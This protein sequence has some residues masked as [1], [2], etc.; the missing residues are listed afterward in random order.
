MICRSVDVKSRV[1]E[2]AVGS[3]Q[4]DRYFYDPLR[5]F[6]PEKDEALM[7][8]QGIGFQEMDPFLR[9]LLVTDGT[10]TRCLEAYL[11]EPISVERCFQEEVLLKHNEP[12]LGVKEGEPVILRKII[13]RGV[14]T[15]KVYTF[16]ESLIRIHLLEEEIQKD[17]LEGRM[18]IGELLR[19]RRLETYREMLEFGREKAGEQLS[20]YFMIKSVDLICYRRYRIHVK[21]LP[22]I[23][24]TENFFE[25]HFR[26]R[27]KR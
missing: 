13:L 20:S 22:V 3:Q 5:G 21:G 12:L 27:E 11:W 17:L 1:K 2:A 18:G 10:V 24:V 14:R 8:D 26:L 25:D 19:D 6:L 9:V 15:R 7:P 16:A 4:K 23:L